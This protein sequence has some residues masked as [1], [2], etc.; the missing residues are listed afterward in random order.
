VAFAAGRTRLARW[1]I[2]FV[3]IKPVLYEEK[4]LYVEINEEALPFKGGFHVVKPSTKYL[5]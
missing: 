1:T 5:L 3:I 4:A 2:N